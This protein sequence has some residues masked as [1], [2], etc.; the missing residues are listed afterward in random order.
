VLA[1]RQTVDIKCQ[2]NYPNGGAAR[3]VR[4]PQIFIL[5]MTVLGKPTFWFANP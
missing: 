3:F 5:D 2:K 4:T 1:G